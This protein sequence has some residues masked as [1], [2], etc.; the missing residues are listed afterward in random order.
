MALTP[1]TAD[2]YAAH[3]A[4]HLPQG[5]AWPRE[6]GTPLDRLMAWA[7]D[8]L[9]RV[10]QRVLALLRE[11]DPR[12]TLE[13]LAEW[14]DEYGLPDPCNPHW[15]FSRAS[16]AQYFDANGVLRQAAVDEPRY[17]FDSLGRPTNQVLVEPRRQNFITNPRGEGTPT[18]VYDWGWFTAS[19]GSIVISLARGAEDNIPYVDVHWAGTPSGAGVTIIWLSATVAAALG[20]QWSLSCFTRLVAGSMANIQFCRQQIEELNASSVIVGLSYGDFAPTSAALRT[21]RRI[22]PRTMSGLGVAT[23]TPKFQLHFSG[24][25]P[26]DATFR[27]ALPQLEKGD[28]A[29]S[30]VLPPVGTRAISTREA[31]VLTIATIDERRA[32]LLARITERLSPTPPTF[33]A[34]AASYG[35]TA[36]IIEH[37]AYTCEMNCEQPVNDE[38]WNHAWTINGTGGMVAEMSCEDG[39]E[40]PLRQWRQAPYECSVRRRAPAHTVP[41]FTYS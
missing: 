39:C 7:G 35:A 1:R 28:S 24:A 10:D 31:D 29:T 34:I 32:R 9:A 16:V 12:F 20:E 21:Q 30:P 6:A 27:I 40:T 14:E 18:L 3:L 4:A 37:R 41:I 19:A 15:A 17:L 11:A 8:G 25:G 23:V 5:D 36:T 13:L 33:I 22:V 38:T 2:D 26:I